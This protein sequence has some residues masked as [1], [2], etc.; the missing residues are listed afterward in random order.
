MSAAA[1]TA[2]MS[3][4]PTGAPTGALTKPVLKIDPSNLAL[5]PKSLS[6]FTIPTIT[7]TP[8]DSAPQYSSP[9]PEQ[10]YEKTVLFV[11]VKT[12]E[13]GWD[14]H[15]LYW[16]GTYAYPVHEIYDKEGL[17]IGRRRKGPA[18]YRFEEYYD[19]KKPKRSSTDQ[20][21][22]EANVRL[23]EPAPARVETA[24]CVALAEDKVEDR[25]SEPMKEEDIVSPTSPTL[26]VA[27]EMSEDASSVCDDSASLWSRADDDE[28]VCTSPGLMSPPSMDVDRETF[29]PETLSKKL[30]DLAPSSP[31]KN[32]WLSLGTL[33][34][35]SSPWSATS[36]SRPQSLP[37]ARTNTS[38]RTFDLI[39]MLFLIGVQL[40]YSGPNHISFCC[41]N[42]GV[43]VA[44]PLSNTSAGNV[45]DGIL[46]KQDGWR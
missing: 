22:E 19:A 7:I 39:A 6:G 8:P 20:G 42:D 24:K 14:E 23:D 12:E 3:Q 13:L 37:I 30:S 28:S 31:T 16:N 2:N 46:A 15:G 17:A 4:L 34:S 26:S 29:A 5:A 21:V 18:G 43:K 11:P 44:I 10:T 1:A 35:C 32:S 45:T 25:Q 41:L 27:S 36:S 9:V 33:P 40:N 38:K